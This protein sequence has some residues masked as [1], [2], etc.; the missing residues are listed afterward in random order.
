M[1]RTDSGESIHAISRADDRFFVVASVLLPYFAEAAY[2][3]DVFYYHLHGK[4]RTGYEGLLSSILSVFVYLQYCAPLRSRYVRLFYHTS[5]WMISEIGTLA[6]VIYYSKEN[7]TFHVVLYSIWAFVDTIYFICLLCCRVIF[8]K[9]KLHIHMAM[10]Q[11]HLFHFISRLEVILAIFIPVFFSTQF[12]TLTRDNIAF[13]ILF[14]FFAESYHRFSGVLI[15]ATLYIFVITVTGSVATEW[16]YVARREHA[17]EIASIICE[18]VA[19]CFCYALIVMQFFPSNFNDE[20]P[21]ERH[22]TVKASTTS[23][24][25]SIPTVNVPD[26]KRNY[27]SPNDI[28]VDRRISF[29]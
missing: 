9:R 18:V 20:K 10:E 22:R 29:F 3:F 14:D 26:V 8:K 5:L 11:E 4:E 16:I 15:K 23:T 24:I 7:D 1:K 27:L 6:H 13:Y 28:D 21:R 19:A 25:P 17:F 12:I 2:L